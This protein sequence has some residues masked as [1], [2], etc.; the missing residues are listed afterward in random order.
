MPVD[1]KAK[2][3]LLVAQWPR[4]SLGDVVICV[5]E[6]AAARPLGPLPKQTTSGLEVEQMISHFCLPGFWVDLAQGTRPLETGRAAYVSVKKRY[7][8]Y[9]FSAT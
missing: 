6:R 3:S 4:A 2:E 1:R 5:A 9:S 8:E 7:Q